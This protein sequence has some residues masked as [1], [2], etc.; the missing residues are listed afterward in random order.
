MSSQLKLTK[1]NRKW[2]HKNCE[3]RKILY[4]NGL[5][6]D[7]IAVITR[8]IGSV[9]HDKKIVCEYCGDILN[10]KMTKRIRSGMPMGKCRLKEEHDKEIK[11]CMED[12]IACIEID[13]V[14]K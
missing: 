8:Y 6:Y 10:L 9:T 12:I 3:K 1:A 7:E 14:G 5:S 11:Q 13:N 4:S 2:L